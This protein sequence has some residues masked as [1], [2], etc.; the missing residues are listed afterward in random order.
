M[1]SNDTSRET[2]NGEVLI[3]HLANVDI[4]VEVV[5]DN[6]IPGVK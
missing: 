6:K 4:I 2:K 5:D 3:S 1:H